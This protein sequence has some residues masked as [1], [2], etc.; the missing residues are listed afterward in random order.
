MLEF[1]GNASLEGKLARSLHNSSILRIWIRTQRQVHRI[2]NTLI[3]AK[4][5]NLNNH[6]EDIDNRSSASYLIQVTEKAMKQ[7]VKSDCAFCKDRMYNIYIGKWKYI[8]QGITKGHIWIWTD[9]WL[10]LF[11]LRVSVSSPCWLWICGNLPVSASQ[12]LG[13]HVCATTPGR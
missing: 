8:S 4:S 12:L 9:R 10:L 3:M 5:G 13:L 1:R 7:Y 6:Q 11:P 2:I